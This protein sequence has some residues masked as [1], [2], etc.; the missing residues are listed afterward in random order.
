MDTDT[1]DSEEG[2]GVEMRKASGFRAHFLSAMIPNGAPTL[3]T[4]LLE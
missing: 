1:D 2:S 3:S 4:D